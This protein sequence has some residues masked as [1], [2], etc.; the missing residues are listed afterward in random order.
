LLVVA[1]AVGPVATGSEGGYRVVGRRF[2]AERRPIFRYALGAI[3]IEE[4]PIPRIGPDG[5]TL[6][7]EFRLTSPRPVEDLFFRD[8]N[9]HIPVAFARDDEGY[10]AQLDVEVVW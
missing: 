9:E 4:R 10:R 6:T 2:D 3:E 8:M 5:G 1:G 7:R